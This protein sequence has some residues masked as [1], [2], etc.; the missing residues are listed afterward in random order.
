MA[1]GASQVKKTALSK[2]DDAVSVR[3]DESVHLWLDVLSNG[4]FEEVVNVDFVVEVTNVSY[5]GV[6]LHLV[7]VLG[8]DDA[9]VAGGGDEDVS[10]GE[11]SLKADD[12]EALHGGL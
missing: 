8:H 4:G 6:V 11:D 5:D 2:E 10:D 9:L 3:E 12:S 7:H 1:G